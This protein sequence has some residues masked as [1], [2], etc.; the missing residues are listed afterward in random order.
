MKLIPNFKGHDIFPHDLR[1]PFMKYKGTALAASV[2]AM[3]LSLAVFFG[4][5]RLIDNV[6]LGSQRNAASA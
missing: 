1:L 4:K 2:I 6:V 5:T 3:A